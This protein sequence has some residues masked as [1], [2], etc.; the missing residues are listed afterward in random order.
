MKRPIPDVSKTHTP[1]GP[2]IPLAVREGADLEGYHRF[3]LPEG[4][5]LEFDRAQMSDA[6]DQRGLH[7]LACG[8]KKGDRVGLVLPQNH[9]FVLTFMGALAVGVVPVPMYPPL[10]LGKLDS[11]V[12]TAEHILEAAQAKA[13]VTEKKVQPVLWS[14]VGKVKSLKAVHCVEDFKERLPGQPDVS[15]LKPG[16]VAFLQFTSGSTSQPKGVM[17]THGNL[18]ANC[19]AIQVDGL[20]CNPKDVGV[21]WLPL[22]HDMGLIGC[23]LSPFFIHMPMTYIPTLTFVKHPTLWM[24][25]MHRVRGTMAFAPNFAYALARRRTSEEKL[26][27][28]DLSCVRILGCGAEPNHPDTLRAFSDHFAKAKLS[29]GAI[30]PC[31]GMAEATLAMTF[32]ELGRGLKTDVIDAAAWHDE[33][34]AVPAQKDAAEEGTVEFVSCGRSFGGHEVMVIK[35]DD[36]PAPERV[37]GEIVYKGPSVTAGY[38]ENAAATKEAFTELGLR[39]GDLGYLAGGELY[40]TGRKK[41]LI[42]LNGRNYDPQSI[43]WEVAEVP[44]IRKGN[45]VA[46][47]VPGT[48]SEELV[49]VCESKETDR[50]KLVAAVKQRVQQ[51]LFL[52]AT[53]VVLIGPGELPKTSSGKLQRRRTREQ[54]LMQS[55]GEEGVRTHGKSAETLMLAKHLG[56]GVMAR[57]KH[58]VKRGAEGLKSALSRDSKSDDEKKD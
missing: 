56:R 4:G 35:E 8:L 13:L 33:G 53:D 57:V 41:D 17:V 34:R 3:L 12:S 37:V 24:E 48:S 9:E 30:L 25:T 2:L 55:L 28:L 38:F 22:Y 21:S 15:H 29:P 49:V 31:Y 16:D 20:K 5:E 18:V 6:I 39:T 46:F 47:S 51:A 10:S 7:L 45:V 36:T 27:K 11:Y 19:Y 42:I 52:N 43:E 54:Y 23:V 26:A 14:L 32:C 40:V 44:G 1:T 58:N 50:E